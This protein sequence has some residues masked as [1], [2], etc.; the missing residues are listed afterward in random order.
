MRLGVPEENIKTKTDQNLKDFNTYLT[1]E[2]KNRLM[3][4]AT[5]NIQSFLFVYCAGHG[6]AD[7]QQYFVLND[8]K[9]QLVTIEAK[10]RALA[11]LTGA[12]IIA[13]YDVCR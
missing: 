9:R 6:V 7:Q 11:N 13:V 10:L 12:N 8:E 2:L 4:K 3:K 1:K 5:E